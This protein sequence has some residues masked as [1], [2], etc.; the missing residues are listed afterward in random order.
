MRLA[1]VFGMVFPF[2]P[3][4][5]LFS[6][7]QEHFGLD[8]GEA[9]LRA[10]MP[11]AHSHLDIELNFVLEGHI[12]LHNGHDEAVVR[13]GETCVFWAA[14][15]HRI[16]EVGTP[17]RHVWVTVPLGLL[18]AWDLPSA[19]TRRILGGGVV[20]DPTPAGMSGDPAAVRR[21]LADRE[22]AGPGVDL[23]GLSG[24]L[25]CRMR[26]FASARL[27]GL[28]GRRSR[29]AAGAVPRAVER[30]A[31]AAA[32]EPAATAA[33]VAR[34]AG[35]HPV[36]AASLF[37][38]HFGIG[39]KEHLARQR[40]AAAQRLLLTTGKSVLEIAYAS[41]FA[42]PGRFYAWFQRLHGCTPRAYRAAAGRVRS[43]RAP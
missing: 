18:L 33:D 13:A 21:W 38:R 26:R 10:P 34:A 32:T 42:T 22:G 6:K 36:Y 20:V 31:R 5:L 15:L 17:H 41:G 14:C 23:P 8:V 7:M 12:V 16:V 4:F 25:E 40:I 24:E 11:D 37:R 28:A 30:M 9:R 19:F 43:P 35:L 27:R 2:P 3:V 29:A 39:I 1:D